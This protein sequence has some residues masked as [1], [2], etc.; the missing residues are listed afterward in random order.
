[1]VVSLLRSQPS[2]FT[3]RWSLRC[4]RGRVDSC[5]PSDSPDIRCCRRR[6]SGE[7]SGQQPRPPLPPSEP[8][9][10]SETKP[11]RPLDSN[12][13]SHYIA[14]L[15]PKL[16]HYKS[17]HVITN[18]DLLYTHIPFITLSRSPTLFPYHCIEA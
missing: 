2:L 6:R 10:R 5:S 17:F 1:M 18:A 15:L 13:P 3:C 14:C 8:Q 11:H 4:L 16:C 12:I 7:A 9:W